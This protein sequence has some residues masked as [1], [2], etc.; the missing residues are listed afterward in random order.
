MSKQNN[1]VIRA[2]TRSRSRAN[3]KRTNMSVFE[4]SLLRTRLFEMACVWLLGKHET[5]QRN[6]LQWECG[7]ERRGAG[8]KRVWYPSHECM[9][10]YT[11]YGCR[12]ETGSP[13]GTRMLD[14]HDGA[15]ECVD[16]RSTGSQCVVRSRTITI[17]RTTKRIHSFFFSF[18][19]PNALANDSKW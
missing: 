5:D 17:N 7:S 4:T 15:R 19:F 16:S 10:G 6:A 9:L 13:A 2:L 1:A 8:L 14:D 12:R 11:G 3:A 18:P